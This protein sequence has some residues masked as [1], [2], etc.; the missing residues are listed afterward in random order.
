MRIE[1]S[2]P[3]LFT[4]SGTIRHFLPFLSAQRQKSG[5]KWGQE[6]KP[7]HSQFFVK[8][9]PFPCR[10]EHSGCNRRPDLP[11]DFAVGY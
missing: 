6:E 11:Y 8:K 2:K 5:K 7:E 4:R 10:A 1:F 3:E 9:P